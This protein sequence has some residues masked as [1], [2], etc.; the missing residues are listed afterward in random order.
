MSEPKPGSTE[1]ETDRIEAFSDGV[2][3][4]AITLL[5]LD[6]KV[7]HQSSSSLLVMLLNLWPAYFAYILSFV[8]IGIYWAQHHYIFKLFQKT[9]HLLN[10]LN[11]FFLLCIAFL[12]F[13]TQVLNEYMLDSANQTAAATFYAF[14]LLLPAGSWFLMWLYAT[15]GRRIVDN[16]LDPGYLR[17]M[18]VQYG[19]SVALYLGAVLLSLIDFRWGLGLCVGLSFSICCHHRVRAMLMTS[20]SASPWPCRA[21]GRA[22]VQE[23]ARSRATS[24]NR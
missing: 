16:R 22:A 18:T 8:M 12:P 21:A 15:H 14:G 1:R 6:I 4:I 11:L 19:G 10:L 7:P 2:F 9:N 13:P 23:R 3:A 24:P 5:I 20:H 17:R